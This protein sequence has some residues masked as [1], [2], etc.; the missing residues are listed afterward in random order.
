MQSLI[1]IYMK[2]E[3]NEDEFNK[4]FDLK[5]LNNEELHNI[6]NSCDS[7]K[8]TD[9][10]LLKIC[11]LR[12]LSDECLLTIIRDDLNDSEITDLFHNLIN[13]NNLSIVD[14]NSLEIEKFNEILK[15]KFLGIMLESESPTE[16]ICKL[17]DKMTTVNYGTHKYACLDNPKYE[18]INPLMFCSY[19]EREDLVKLLVEKYNA[20]ID[21]SSFC[22]TT[23]IMFA[24]RN[25][26]Q[27]IINYLC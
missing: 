8:L 24:A 14:F 25:D 11:D 9:Q 1:R 7:Q 12:K 2:I 20:D 13:S 19:E 16:L 21:F 27:E 15:Q 3:W 6:S 5:K 4:Y 22:D 10:D 17:L 23:S 18:D 26:D